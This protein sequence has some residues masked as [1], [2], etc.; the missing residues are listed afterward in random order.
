M[1]PTAYVA[2]G[3]LRLGASSG[4]EIKRAVDLSIRF[5]W[6]I[7]QAQIYPSLERFERAGLVRG[8]SEPR[9]KRPRRAYEVTDDGEAALAE[10]LRTDDPIPY[11][12]RDLAM[13]KLFFADLLERDDALEILDSMRRR[14]EERI[15]V[16]RR[17]SWP[18]AEAAAEAGLRFPFA[19][20]RIGIAV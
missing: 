17:E 4:Y 16:L 9:G 7:S 11:E 8:R 18:V 6:T 3:M 10:W 15:R 2:L 5:F 13:V 1:A 12:V 14:S 20:L 19:T